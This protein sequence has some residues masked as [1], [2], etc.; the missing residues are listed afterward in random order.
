MTKLYDDGAY[1]RVDEAGLWVPE[2][3]KPKAKEARVGSGGIIAN[4]LPGDLVLVYNK[5]GSRR[6]RAT[7]AWF[8]NDGSA[9]VRMGDS[10]KGEAIR[11]MPATARVEFRK[12][13]PK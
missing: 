9:A 1:K 13:R 2:R 4:C 5:S 11:T 3:T 10:L 8:Y 12:L 7:I 6:Y